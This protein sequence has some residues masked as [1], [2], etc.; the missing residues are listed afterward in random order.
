MST[1]TA[2]D[3][4]LDD[5]DTALATSTHRG[6]TVMP[7]PPAG[8][9]P[10]RRDVVLAEIDAVLQAKDEAWVAERDARFA[11][12]VRAGNSLALRG[13][14]APPVGEVQG[15]TGL[16][17][18]QSAA[19]A[20]A[21]VPELPPIPPAV[22]AVRDAIAA[23]R[24]QQPQ[25]AQQASEQTTG[26]RTWPW[27]RHAK[28]A[29][30]L[31]DGVLPTA[32]PLMGALQGAVG[33]AA[34]GEAAFNIFKGAH[35]LM[36]LPLYMALLAPMLFEAAA[37]SYAI[38]DLRDRRRGVKSTLM[39]GAAWTGISVSAVVGGV[40]GFFLYGP[41]GVLA[42]AASVVF[43]TMLHVHGDRA[44]RAHE[45]RMKQSEPWKQAQQRA[46]ETTSARDVLTLLLP[47]DADGKATAD[48]L[49]KRMDAG[50]LTPGD[51]LIAA[52]WH[53]RTDRGLSES[54]MIR[55]ETVAATVW[56]KDGLP[57]PP[58]PP[59]S[60][61]RGASRRSSPHA[62]GAG[63]TQAGASAAWATQAGASRGA[64]PTGAPTQPPQGA[65]QATQR[66]HLDDAALTE[67]VHRHLVTHPEDGERPIGRALNQAGFSGSAKR[68]REA[69]TAIKDQQDTPQSIPGA[70]AAPAPATEGGDRR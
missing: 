37:S 34:A 53:R 63:S 23:E 1:D 64:S 38:Q 6:P 32:G 52:G 24:H 39:A 28:D 14:G 57:S 68:I 61:G 56:G 59:A 21:T 3:A 58:A 50:T 33:A 46:A 40:V 25:P 62:T 55:L 35:E 44:V 20:V 4:V 48:L 2:L 42:A 49:H 18:V 26:A 70:G 30:D 51:A 5:I 7:A 15:E 22:A 19:G 45:S 11:E 31:D 43:G 47:R 60:P 12:I 27:Q 69:L 41:F 36:H 8:P 9:V 29:E 54:Q 13:V 10:G 67:W 66:R 17:G 16:G 65:S